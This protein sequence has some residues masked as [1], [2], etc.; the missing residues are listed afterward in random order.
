MEYVATEYSINPIEKLVLSGKNIEMVKIYKPNNSALVNGYVYISLVQELD[1]CDMLLDINCDAMLCDGL[2]VIGPIQNYM[3]IP[4]R[5]PRWK[6]MTARVKPLAE[7]LFRIGWLQMEN[8]EKLHMPEY[9]T[10]PVNYN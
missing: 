7:I 1:N 4:L 9:K 5:I 3:P 6:N 2:D 10:I 8:I